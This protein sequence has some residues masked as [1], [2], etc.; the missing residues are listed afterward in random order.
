M[1]LDGFKSEQPRDAVPILSY[2][3]IIT[4]TGFVWVH[5]AAGM[6]TGASTDACLY[7]T[8]LTAAAGS[9]NAI[10]GSQTVSLPT[11]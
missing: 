4:S 7:L 11:T 1:I 6:N 2:P 3:G 8:V 10:S 5:L 9:P